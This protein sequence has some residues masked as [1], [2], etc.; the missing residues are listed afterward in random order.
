M[1]LM[2]F[3]LLG[4]RSRLWWPSGQKWYVGGDFKL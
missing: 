4:Q 1:T 2:I 3:R